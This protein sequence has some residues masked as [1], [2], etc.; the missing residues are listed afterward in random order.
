MKIL[1]IYD[2]KNHIK[3]KTLYKEPSLTE[4]SFKKDSDVN[5]VL[6]RFNRTGQ[7]Q[8]LVSNNPEIYG[9]YSEAPDFMAAQQIIRKAQEQ[10]QMLPSDLRNRFSNDPARFLEFMNDET[11]ND[12]KVLLGLKVKKEPVKKE[13]L[14]K[15]D[16][17]PKEAEPPASAAKPSEAQA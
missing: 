11:N 3:P 4:Q 14:S 17:L 6:E 5:Y 1:S 16:A 13:E 7:I 9:D 2:R 12:E 15:A 10:F 8:D